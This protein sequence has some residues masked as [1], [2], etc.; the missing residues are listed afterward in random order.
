MNKRQPNLQEEPEISKN[1][2][3]VRF[4]TLDGSFENGECVA[5]ISTL[6]LRSN[7]R[8]ISKNPDVEPDVI[9]W[10]IE[11]EGDS[12]RTVYVNALIWAELHEMLM[13][14]VIINTFPQR[15]EDKY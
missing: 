8:V 14:K 9:D 4:G 11:F 13:N 12:N 7:V 6:R 15:P 5:K 1:G 2:R 10:W 3:Y